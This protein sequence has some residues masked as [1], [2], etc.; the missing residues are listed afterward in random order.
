MRDASSVSELFAVELVQANLLAGPEHEPSWSDHS[1]ARH[2][3]REGRMV[4]DLGSPT[5]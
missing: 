2:H 5:A 1:M 3:C 4:G